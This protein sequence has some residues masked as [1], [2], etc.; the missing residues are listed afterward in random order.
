[1]PDVLTAFGLSASAGLNAYIPMLIIALT[2]RFTNLVELSAPYDLLENGWVIAALTVLLIVE[3]LADKVPVVDH[4]NDAI[5]TLV[6]P[7]A[8]ALLFAAASGSV[9]DIDPRVA[10]ILGFVVAGAT[11]GA[12]ATARPMVTASTGG[13]GNP[14]ISTVEDVAALLTSVVAVLAPVLIGAGLVVLLALWLWW[15]VRRRQTTATGISRAP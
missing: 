11:H 13:I 6:R 12:K 8:G 14:V 5:G 10:M 9:V 7:T 15:R 2:A 1:M 3:V 4:V